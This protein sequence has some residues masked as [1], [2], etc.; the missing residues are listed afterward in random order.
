VAEHS[1]LEIGTASV[2]V[3]L[4]VMFLA[5]GLGQ[6]PG[7]GTVANAIVLGLVVDALLSLGWVTRLGERGFPLRLSLLALG[8]VLFGLGSALYIG[9]GLGAGPRDSLMLV[10]SRRTGVRIAAVRA[11]IELTAIAI[12]WTLGGT[13]GLGTVAIAF[14]LGPSVE[15]SFWLFARAGLAG[16]TPALA[17]DPPLAD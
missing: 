17:L 1:P 2:V 8:V 15:G 7:F 13:V 16:R 9:A 11:S 14:L 6:P 10:L 4:A 12:G 5:W 3:G